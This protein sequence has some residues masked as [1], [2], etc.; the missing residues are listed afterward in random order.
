MA[1]GNNF[2]FGY[3]SR[4]EK[5]KLA[6]LKIV[7]LGWTAACLLAVIFWYHKTSAQL[8]TAA[9]SLAG[10]YFYLNFCNVQSEAMELFEPPYPLKGNGLGI[11]CILF[12]IAAIYYQ[13]IGN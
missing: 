5:I 4:R 8:S 12:T 2:E 6:L 10:P 3:M 7:C 13:W 9:A 1:K 11:V